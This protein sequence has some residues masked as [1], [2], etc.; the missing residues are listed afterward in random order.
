MTVIED[1]ENELKKIENK[2]KNDVVDATEEIKNFL[3]KLEEMKENG[4]F[5]YNKEVF[6]KQKESIEC[7]KTFDNIFKDALDIDMSVYSDGDSYFKPKRT[8]ILKDLNDATAKFEKYSY[9]KQNSVLPN[10]FWMSITRKIYIYDNLTATFQIDNYLNVY[11]PNKDVY[12]IMNR[13]AF[14]LTIFTLVKSITDCCFDV[15]PINFF[16]YKKVNKSVSYLR[17]FSFHVEN[18]CPFDFLPKGYKS[19]YNL[20]NKFR[21]LPF[22]SPK[23]YSLKEYSIKENDLEKEDSDE[24]ELSS[25]SIDKEDLEENLKSSE[26]DINNAPIENNSNIISKYNIGDYEN[27]ALVKVPDRFKCKPWGCDNIAFLPKPLLID[28]VWDYIAD[29]DLEK[30]NSI[31]ISGDK[32]SEIAKLFNITPK[33]SYPFIDL[34]EIEIHI[35][36]MLYETPK[37]SQ[38][39]VKIDFDES[40]EAITDEESSNN[41]KKVYVVYHKVTKGDVI[42]IDE[43]ILGVFNKTKNALKCAKEKV[44]SIGTNYTTTLDTKRQ[45]KIFYKFLFNYGYSGE[46]ISICGT[47]LN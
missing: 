26:N 33:A 3:K 40:I 32:G 41:K 11:F 20:F 21:R 19:I 15:P 29:N 35:D 6:K 13:T 45:D 12:L 2:Y 36:K 16:N 34:N 38:K 23:E 37:Y 10:R 18:E 42:N 43:T 27:G 1:I 5:S 7:S 31:A 25:D 30:N 4:I 28:M 39:D 47:I 22:Y 24:P 8:F 46:E 14:P 9:D 44:N 17:D